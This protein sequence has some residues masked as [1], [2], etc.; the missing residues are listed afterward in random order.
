MPLRSAVKKFCEH[1]NN[2][3]DKIS[4]LFASTWRP[5]REI[6]IKSLPL[7]PS[8]SITLPLTITKG[9]SRPL[10][11]SHEVWTMMIIAIGLMCAGAA[12]KVEKLKVVLKY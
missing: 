8:S 9:G 10:E 2:L 3:C 5:L 7:Y 6:V 11:K 1:K 12:K 4:Y